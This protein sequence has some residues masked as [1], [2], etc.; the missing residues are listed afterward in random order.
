MQGS[1]VRG[2]SRDDGRV[3]EKANVRF[4]TCGFVEQ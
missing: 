1:W 2:K 4:E 3:T